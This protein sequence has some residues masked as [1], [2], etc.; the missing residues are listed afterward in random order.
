MTVQK[1]KKIT[2]SDVLAAQKQ[3]ANIAIQ[4]P[5]KPSYTLSEKTG[6]QVWL[7]LENMQPTGAFKLR[8]AANA[9][10]N[11]TDEQ[12]SKGVVTMSTGNHGKAVAYVTKKLGMRAVICVS[13]IVPKVKL[14]GMRKLGVEVLIYGKDQ[15][16]ADANAKTISK[17]QG[18]H[19]ISAF[20]DPNV[21]AGQGTIALE[22]LEQQPEIDTLIVP[23][24]GGGLMSGI[25]IAVKTHR[26]D[27]QLIGVSMTHGAAMHLSIKAGKIVDVEELPSL[28]DALTGCI[29]KDNKYSFP[30]CKKYVDASYLVSEEAI[31]KAMVYAL[32]NERLILEG[33]AC[34]P[35]ALLH[36]NLENIQGKNIAL[37]CT[38]DNVDILSLLKLCEQYR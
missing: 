12:K 35:I 21:I 32:Q 3:I 4:T 38:G 25:A 13:E 24:S 2:F 36:E 19:Y 28:A 31:G 5:L 22:I 14:E 27:I 17:E 8:G 9:I 1:S 7:K 15:E 18:L 20:D 34:T 29:P 23:L 16:E 10:L 11:L 33:G 37:I 30:I 26:P 6:K